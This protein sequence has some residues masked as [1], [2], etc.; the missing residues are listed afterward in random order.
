MVALYA[1]LLYYLL[2]F[3][4]SVNLCHTLCHLVIVWYN[5]VIMSFGH[6]HHID[7]PMVDYV[8]DPY[9]DANFS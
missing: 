3:M 4:D 8:G 7:F 2:C 6:C 9:S 1:L 5:F